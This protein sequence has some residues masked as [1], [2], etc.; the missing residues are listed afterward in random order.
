MFHHFKSWIFL[1][2]GGV[3]PPEVSF[4]LMMPSFCTCNQAKYI[5]VT[6]QIDRSTYLYLSFLVAFFAEKVEPVFG[7][8]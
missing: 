5:C 3:A 1:K 2:S 7:N 6:K 4:D 8:I